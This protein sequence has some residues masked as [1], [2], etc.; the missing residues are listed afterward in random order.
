MVLYHSYVCL[1]DVS[2]TLL[3]EHGEHSL[4]CYTLS[5]SHLSIC[6]ETEATFAIKLNAVY[7]LERLSRNCNAED[8][9]TNRTK[10]VHE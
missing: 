5:I 10:H 3:I 4:V 1:C 9:N 7:F 6:K 2:D 8:K